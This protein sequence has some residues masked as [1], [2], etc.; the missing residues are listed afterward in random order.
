V[1]EKRQAGDLSAALALGRELLKEHPEDRFLKNEIGWVLYQKLKDC[2]QNA[3]AFPDQ[4]DNQAVGQ[5]IRNYLGEY[6][7]L[8]L[9]RP[10]LLFSLLTSWAFKAPGTK[11]FF[12]VMLNGLELALT[13]RKITTA[14]RGTVIAFWIR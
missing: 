12:Q 10:D 4:T 13:D 9:D 8:N 5:Q 3:R 6:S 11:V 2:V 7:R 14:T 1:K